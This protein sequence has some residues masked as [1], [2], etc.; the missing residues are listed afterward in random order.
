M[1]T[2]LKNIENLALIEGVL[3]GA[4]PMLESLHGLGR[5]A[6]LSVKTGQPKQDL[7]LGLLC[8]ASGRRYA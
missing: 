8:S 5:S 2:L 6:L 7:V 1:C 4:G 3:D